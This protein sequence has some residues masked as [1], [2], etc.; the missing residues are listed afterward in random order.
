[1]SD[2]PKFIRCGRAECGDLLQAERREWLVTNQ[3]GGYAAGTIAGTL[4]RHYHGLLIAPIHASRRLLFA[5]ADA[6][7]LDGEREIPLFSNR[8]ATNI[9]NPQGYVH[10]ESFH[11]DGRMP[12]WRYALGDLLLEQRIWMEPGANTTYIAWRLDQVNR[13]YAPQL[14]VQLLINNR[15]HHADTVL[16]AFQPTID[17]PHPAQRRIIDPDFTLW[18]SACGGVIS[19]QS[20]WFEYFDLPIERERGLAHHDHHFCIGEATLILQPGVWSGM[21]ASLHEDAAL[22]FDAAQQRFR[23]H[24]QSLLQQ[25]NLALPNPPDWIAQLTLSADS[26]LIERPLP[27]LLDGASVIAGYPWFDVWGRDA[28]IA[29]PG[30]TLATGRREIARRILRTFAQHIENGLLPNVFS[31]DGEALAY[32][33][34]DAALWYIEAYRAYLQ[35]SGKLA[36]VAEAFPVLQ[37][38]IAWHVAGTRFGIALDSADGLLRCG[39]PGLQLT[40]MDAKIGDW[41][42]TPRIG[43]PVEINALWYNALCS[44]ATCARL[45]GQSPTLYDDLAQQAQQGFQRFIRADGEGLLDV[46]DG[47]DGDEALVRPNQLF[48][49]SLTYSPLERVAQ[50][51]VVRVCSRDLLT[52]YGLRSLSPRH[53]AFRPRYIGD[54]YERDSSYHQGPVWGWLLGHYALADFRVSGDADAARAWLEPLRDHLSDAG[55]GNISEIFDGAP[56]H[57][58]RGTPA[59]AWSVACALQA[60]WQLSSAP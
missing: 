21:V 1:M 52:S 19:D 26:F 5:K 30:L 18:L 22:D 47:P 49:V 17:M 25:A 11:L 50:E 15:D 51:A 13:T 43:K 4:T 3:L 2:L 45:L 54:M 41:V 27:K 16:G 36:D 6:T 9:V 57:Y 12:V 23:A 40:W 60:W 32:N 42:V 38:I 24:D 33:T 34:A 46:I 14:R 48:A 56:P 53:A 10:L 8:W 20:N 58:P 37:E 35:D 39:E 44:V 28:M 55:L 7:L 59:Q 31:P 29:L